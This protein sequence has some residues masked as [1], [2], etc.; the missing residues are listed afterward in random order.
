MFRSCLVS[1]GLC[2]LLTSAFR[3]ADAR[4]V[5]GGMP[6]D[7]IRHIQDTIRHIQDTIHRHVQDTLSPP[8][9]STEYY[10]R[11]S[12][13]AP[14]FSEARDS[15]IQDVADGRRMFYYYGDVKVKY[16]NMEMMAEYMEY[17]ANTGIVF[18]RGVADSTGVL[19]GNPEMKDGD[20]TYVM[21]SVYYNFE[22]RKAKIRDIIF[23]EGEGFLHGNDIKKMP[24][25]SFNIARGKYTTC[26]CEHPHFYLQLTSAKVI[27]DGPSQKTVLGPAFLVLEDVP[28]PL[29]IPFG[30]VPQRPDRAGG[31]LMPN[32]GE[33]VSRGFF[34]R[35]LGYYFVLGDHLD[36]SLTGDV[37]TLGSWALRA[38]SRYK[39]MYKF[40]GNFNIN[41]SS[42]ITG[43]RGSA[44]FF[45]SR[46]FA[47]QWAHNQDAKARPGTS[48]R[49]SVNFSSPSNS[50]YNSQS[51]QQ[52]LQNQIASSVSYAKNFLG[53]PFRLSVNLNHSQSSIDSS[54]ALTV[55][56]FSFNMDRI[57][58]FK[59]KDRAGK[60]RMYEKFALNY[61]TTFD[62]KMNFKASDVSS[63]ELLSKMKVG[64]QHTFGITLP[65]MSLF[66]YIQLAPSVNYGMNWHFQDKEKVYDPTIGKVVDNIA[67]PFT[68]FGITQSYGGSLNISTRLYGIFPFSEKGALQ[69][70]RHIL[71]PSVN[72]SLRPELGT[73]ANGYRVLSYVDT[74]GKAHTLPYNIYES[75][76]YGAPGRGKTASLNFSLSNN[77][78][79]KVRNRRDTTEGGSRIIKLIDNLSLSGGYNF[80]AD[81]MKLSPNIGATMNTTIMEK[82]AL[83]AN[84]NFNPYAVNER[85]QPIAT[86]NIVKEGRLARLTGAGLSFS[87]QF[88]GGGG[89]GQ[90]GGTPVNSYKLIYYHPITG[91]YIPGGWVY[92]MESNLPWSLNMSYNYNYSLAYQYA[93]EQ[94]QKIHS[95]IQTLNLSGQLRFTK[96][97]NINITSGVDVMKLKL[98]TTQFSATYDLHCFMISVNWVPQGKWSQ[99]SFNIRAKASALADLLKYDRKASFWDR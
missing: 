74:L 72:I 57:Y 97:F 21:K 10:A 19:Q 2:L 38:T 34:L 89:S 33:E 49:A 80:L 59:N 28:L 92:Y 67:D 8:I 96:D 60:E 23:Q 61:G 31:L 29:L 22:T 35:D 77:L 93:N 7:T 24:D 17:D 81:S 69:R 5:G 82:L 36:F 15:L 83:N 51:V 53:T 62:N 40:D 1:L 98:T 13:D 79:A 70:V 76:T 75:S 30:F 41:M 27:R 45:E 44:D 90:G 9:D 68:T 86:Y 11:A 52:A 56:N 47:V 55:P 91:E 48:F 20:K 3:P 43:E 14:L 66:K 63:G 94:L 16:Q 39:T 58:P 64:M 87:Y 42:D 54:Y 65:S 85:G 50:R 84:A 26:D 95:H 73:Y 4:M 18:A 88:S 99:W 78:E 6:Q 37:Y 12:I 25:N 32:Y 46:N 71:T